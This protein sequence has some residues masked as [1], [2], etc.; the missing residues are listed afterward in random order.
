MKCASLPYDLF[1]IYAL[2][3][4]V[5]KV[6]C[7]YEKVGKLILDFDLREPAIVVNPKR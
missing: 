5:S 1:Q 3:L 4:V 2:L 6:K 7:V